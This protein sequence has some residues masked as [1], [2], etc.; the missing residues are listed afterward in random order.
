[1]NLFKRCVTALIIIIL[2]GCAF[3]LFLVYKDG[4]ASKI[5]KSEKSRISALLSEH[6][7]KI[8]KN[9]LPEKY[10]ALP[11]IYMTNA[12]RSRYSFSS[13]LLGSSLEVA[14]S[15]SYTGKNT[16]LTFNDNSFSLRF[17]SPV[18]HITDEKSV[19]DALD[20]LHFGSAEI[21]QT[22]ENNCIS[23]YK[24]VNGFCIFDCGLDI[25]LSNNC[26]SEINGLWFEPE[27]RLFYKKQRPLISVLE[28]LCENNKVSR[29][30]VTAVTAGYKI[31]TLTEYKKEVIAYPVWRI[32][33]NDSINYDFYM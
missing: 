8:S 28:E 2:T 27:Q 3:L 32:T 11:C 12:S 29:T 15:N 14:D 10:P 19:K 17:Y 24:T 33:L 21:T 7:I 13:S 30:T 31:G 1:M 25:K 5:T 26:I 18:F 23:V 22:D 20:S 6:N 4:S 9:A 16:A